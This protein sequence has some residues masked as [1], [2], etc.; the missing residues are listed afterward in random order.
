M[1]RRTLF[2]LSLTGLAGC[3]RSKLP[4]L[5][6]FNWSDYVAPQTIP[7]FAREFHV[8]VRYSVYESNEEM[9]AKVFSGNSGWDIVFP[10]NYFI[11]PM[12]ANRLLAELDHAQLPNLTNLDGALRRPA[13]DP[14]LRYCVPYMWGATGI[15]YQKALGAPPERWAD[16]WDTRFTGR[17]T[18]LDDPADT[19]GAALKKLGLSINSHAADEM[20]QAQAELLRQKPLVRAYLNAEARDQVVAGDL[21]A[22]HLWATT[23]AQAIEA[24]P[25]RLAF[26]YP[27]EGFPLYADNAV[28][29]RESRRA[30]IA[31]QFIN[32]L[33]R[34]EVAAAVVTV[35][36]TATANRAARERLPQA[37]RDNRVLYPEPETLA[38]GEWFEPLPLAGQ[39]LRDRLWTEIKSA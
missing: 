32:Y 34:P 7:D 26:A 15:V 12:R 19:L 2:F 39:R 31:H 10:S 20:R 11:E 30:D 17:L 37:M 4:R 23:S 28:I 27:R 38:R 3:R 25:E 35:S 36:K 24:A 16:L 9:L 14:D 13:W 1:T 33:L 8:D 18:M 6:V 22:A 21:L 29:L 5:N